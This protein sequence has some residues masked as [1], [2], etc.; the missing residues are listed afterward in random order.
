[1]SVLVTAVLEKMKGIVVAADR[2]EVMKEQAERDLDHFFKEKIYTLSDYYMYRI[3]AGMTPGELQEALRSVNSE[4]LQKHIKLLHSEEAK[5]AEMAEGALG[6]SQDA[7]ALR[8][9]GSQPL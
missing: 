4:E 1:M 7:P 2:L 3:L 6:S 9:R 8:F 5:I